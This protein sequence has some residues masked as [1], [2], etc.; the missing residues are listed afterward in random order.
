MRTCVGERLHV[1]GVVDT[2][3]EQLIIY[4]SCIQ[5]K[6]KSRTFIFQIVALCK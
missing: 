5:Q 2:F 1:E 3:M 4:F 6:F